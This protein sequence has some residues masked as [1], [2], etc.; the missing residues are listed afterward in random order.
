MMK[1]TILFIL[2]IA[3]L[4][5]TGCGA[6]SSSSEFD[7]TPTTQ[8]SQSKSPEKETYTVGEEILITAEATGP[9]NNKW[10]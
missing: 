2:A 9:R 1:K 5:M 6:T 7:G 8:I 3:M 4:A 10:R